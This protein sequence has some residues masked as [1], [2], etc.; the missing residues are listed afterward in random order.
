MRSRNAGWIV[1]VRFAVQ[2]NITFE[3]SN[4]TPEVVVAEGV[5]LLGVEHLEQGRARVAAEV[6]AD[7]VHL[8][9]HEDRVVGARLV[10]ALDDAAGH[11]AHV[12]AAVAAD[13]GLVL[14]AAER[15]AH[16]LAARARARSS[17]RGWSCPTP[18]G[19]TKQRSGPFVF[20]L[21]LRTA[22]YST[23][24]SLTFSRP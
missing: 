21:S 20:S 14:D 9:H 4:G 6:G 2:M 17:G 13:L 5:V 12:G 3:R 24:R 19:P 1:S 15:E 10:D 8:V 7:L 11:R 18:G 23:M 22:R 16:E